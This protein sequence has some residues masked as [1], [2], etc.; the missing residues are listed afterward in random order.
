MR[1]LLD[2]KVYQL[3]LTDKDDKKTVFEGPLDTD[4]NE[5]TL[6]RVDPDTKETQQIVMNTAA[7]G[8]RFIYR[9]AHKEDGSQ[10]YR[11]DFLVQA[12]K[13][14]RGARGRLRRRTS[15]WSAAASARSRSATRARRFGSAAPAART[16]SRRTRRSTSRS[17]RRRRE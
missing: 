6:S 3:T 13:R 2:K 8:V 17:S 12:T 10:L 9:M 4:K 11:K 14:R 7:E 16:L 15:A 1:Y 5:L